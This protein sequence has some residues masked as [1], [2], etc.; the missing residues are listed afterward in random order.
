MKR[1][2]NLSNLF[3]IYERVTAGLQHWG[4]FLAESHF[5]VPYLFK[6]DCPIA[7]KRL[8]KGAL[9]KEVV[10]TDQNY[11]CHLQSEREGYHEIQTETDSQQQ[12]KE[13]CS[14]QG[15]KHIERMANVG[16]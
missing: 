12:K 2:S 3:Q 8:I 11:T 10:A 14:T 9:L 15:W 6:E 1:Q 4:L 16:H 5:F 7:R 13:G